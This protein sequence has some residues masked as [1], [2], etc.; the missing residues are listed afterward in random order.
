M[1]RE[2]RWAS[3]EPVFPHR[4]LCV[5][6]SSVFDRKCL[7]LTSRLSHCD[8]VTLENTQIFSKKMS[9]LHPPRAICHVSTQYA[10][11]SLSSTHGISA[12]RRLRPSLNLGEQERHPERRARPPFAEDPDARDPSPSDYIQDAIRTGH[13]MKDVI[14]VG[15][16]GACDDLVDHIQRRW[17]TSPVIKLHCRGKHANDMK[18][19]AHELEERTGGS[20]LFRSG[21]T[22]IL[23]APGRPM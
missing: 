11:A 7:L 13:A 6:W 18:N 9:W 22:I 2:G 17:K 16:R 8:S 4:K 21:G 20:V 1:R 3:N 15:R 12:N 14:K 5:P 23:H 19:L 10:L